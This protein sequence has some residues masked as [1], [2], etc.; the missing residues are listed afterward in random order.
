MGTCRVDGAAT[1]LTRCVPAASS[2]GLHPCRCLFAADHRPGS[3]R[4]PML[5]R[6]SGQSP[7]QVTVSGILAPV[8]Q[9]GNS[10]LRITLTVN[11]SYKQF[12][13]VDVS[14][15][16]Q[17]RTRGVAGFAEATLA[18]AGVRA[19]HGISEVESRDEPEVE[20]GYVVSF[21]CLSVSS[22]V[23]EFC[24]STLSIHPFD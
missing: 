19:A 23:L 3:R 22:L 12:H 2:W 21:W 6:Y 17:T 18:R 10:A 5:G 1:P 7:F 15:G 14:M 20:N 4:Q 11:A 16:E 9:S 13:R 24:R 8:R